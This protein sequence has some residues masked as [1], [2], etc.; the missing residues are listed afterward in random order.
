MRRRNLLSLGAAA[1]AAPSIARAQGAGVLRFIAEADLAILD[2]VWTTAT[3]THTHARMVFDSLY[4]FDTSY[5]PQPQMLAG[6]EVSGNDWTLRLR[7]GLKFHNGEKVLA[8]DAVASI[9]RWAARDTFG[10]AMMDITDELS[11]P[12]DTSIRLRM[13]KRFPIPRALANSALVMPEH[14]A[15]TDPSKQVTEMIGSGP[16][17]FLA[18]ERVPGARVA[19]ARFEGY[20]PRDEPV[21]QSAGSKRAFVDRVEWMVIPDPSTG[22]AAMLAGEADWWGPP[23]DLLP[24][25]RASP[26]LRLETIDPLGGIAIL[27]FNH[28]QPPF[29]NPAIRRALLGAVSQAEFMTVVS[30]DDKTLWRDGVGAFTP[31][32]PMASDAGM[33]VLRGPRDLAKVRADL[34]AAGYK[35]EKV[36]MMNP[37]DMNELSAITVAAADLLKRCGMNVDL[38]TMDWGTLIQR[39]AK[40]GPSSEG[41]WNLVHTNLGGGGTMDPAGHIGLRANGLKAWAG[42]PTSPELE[43]LRDAWFD[44]SDIA[45]Q[46]DICVEMQKRFWVDVPYIPL[47]QRFFPH[48]INHRVRD[49]PKGGTYFYGVKL[50]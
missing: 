26:K 12:D 41:G 24:K 14:L 6:H 35:G 9:R 2:P 3:V 48:A 19:Y 50:A 10:Q 42:W 30:G 49:V 15:L 28:L 37:A 11:A 20:V 40:T 1:L 33:E 31:G 44:T 13:K 23:P 36:V 43:R 45:A 5:V 17:R 18:A 22:L 25:L 4:G 27:R 21:S 34:A 46:H 47:G 39:R 7:P 38:Q 16:F 32:S 8:R 29:D